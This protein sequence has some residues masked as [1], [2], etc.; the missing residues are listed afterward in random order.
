M[1]RI[2]CAMFLLLWPLQAVSQALPEPLTDT[3]SDFADLLPPDTEARVTEALIAGRKETGVH[4]VVVTLT[5]LAEYGGA[6][7]RIED[8]AKTLFNQWGVG[9]KDRDD[10]IMILIARD[11]RAMRIALGSGYDSIW[12]NNA[13]RVIDRYFLPAF[14]ADDYAGGI[15]AGVPATFDL[16]AAP[17]VAGNP[18]P[19]PPEPEGDWVDFA[20]V[21]AVFAFAAVVIGTILKTALSDVLVGFKAC[22]KC[23]KRHLSRHRDVLVAATRSSIGHGTVHTR[24]SAC[25]YHDSA[26]YTISRVSDN[27]SSSGGF[28]GGSSSG[29]GATGRW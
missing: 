6:G 10:G 2:L 27:D 18:P 5:S 1:P 11:D 21:G 25:G 15:E 29:G 24:C 26:T 22:P 7:Q 3:I 14:R 28:G 12:D 4:V 20:A 13:Q 19:P 16:I 17:F 23:G 8:Y 9:D